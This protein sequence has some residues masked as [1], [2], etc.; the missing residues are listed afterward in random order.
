MRQTVSYGKNNLVR[1]KLTLLY[2]IELVINYC[3]VLIW[4]Y[5]FEETSCTVSKAENSSLRTNPEFGHRAEQW[6]GHC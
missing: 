5:C 4:A 2:C 6:G 3:P 1:T